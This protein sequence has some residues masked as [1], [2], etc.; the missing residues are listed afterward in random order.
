MPR[1]PGRIR[2]IV[3]V[4]GDELTVWTKGFPEGDLDERGHTEGVWCP[5]CRRYQI[6]HKFIAWTGDTGLCFT[7]C[8]VCDVMHAI[9]KRQLETAFNKSRKFWEYVKAGG[10]ET[11]QA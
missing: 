3:K 5:S 4:Y 8:H 9:S 1:T 2:P 10:D 7:K 6:V 11:P